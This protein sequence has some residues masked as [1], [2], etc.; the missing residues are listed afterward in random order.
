MAVIISKKEISKVEFEHLSIRLKE[1][2]KMMYEARMLY[3]D[4]RVKQDTIKKEID[5]YKLFH[6]PEVIISEVNNK[7]LGHKWVGRVRIPS[8]F[9]LEQELADKRNYLTF[10]ICEGSK[11]KDKNDP[12]LIKQA[13]DMAIEKVKSKT[14]TFVQYGRRT[15]KQSK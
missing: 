1:L 5:Y 9:I 7:N 12:N 2:E 15:S 4:L 3:E 14:M 10:N 8:E 11:Y 13:K 6:A